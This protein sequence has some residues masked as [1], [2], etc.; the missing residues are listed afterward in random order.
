MDKLS[1]RRNQL[2]AQGAAPSK[3][4]KTSERASCSRPTSLGSPMFNKLGDQPDQ[5]LQAFENPDVE[6][7]SHLSGN[8]HAREEVPLLPRATELLTPEQQRP[9]VP[10][11][12]IRNADT[13][14]NDGNMSYEM[15]RHFAPPRDREVAQGLP[16]EV[17]EQHAVMSYTAVCLALVKLCVAYYL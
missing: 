17:L 11:W 4:P 6:E 7:I 2:L 15:L 5:E 16:T 10:N 13:V 14:I 1:A 9:Y 8:V 3:K 12:Q